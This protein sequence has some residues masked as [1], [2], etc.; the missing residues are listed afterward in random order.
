MQVLSGID[1]IRAIREWEQGHRRKP[2]IAM[3]AHAMAGDAEKFLSAGMDGDVS[4][5][6]QVGYF[7]GRNGSPYS[8]RNHERW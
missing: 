7:A 4:K 8:I 6:I 1:A 5:P 3:T 2:I